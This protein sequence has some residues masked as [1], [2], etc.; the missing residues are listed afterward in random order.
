LAVLTAPVAQAEYLTHHFTFHHLPFL[1][2]P[3]PAR[4]LFIKSRAGFDFK[5][6]CFSTKAS[7]LLVAGLVQAAAAQT[8]TPLAEAPARPKNIIKFAPLGLIHGSM[9]FTV[10]SRLSYERVLGRRSSVAAGASY[11]GTNYAFSLIGSFALSAAISSAFTLSG[12]PAIVWTQTSIRSQ[13][14]RYQLQYKYYFGVKS[15]APEGWYLS[16]HFS[17]TTVDYTFRVKD[18]DAQVNAKTKNRNY[19]LLV[20]YQKVLGR[21]FTFDVFSGLG[22]RDNTTRFFDDDGTYLNTFPRGTSLKLSS[23]LNLG[24]AF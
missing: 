10:E 4:H 20:G 11:L 17:Y 6:M 2:S 12:H 7:I 14:A 15:R 18:L 23:G 19:N 5:L 1:Y 21:H 8:Q 22:Y 13:G 3:L 24:W 9:P 16:P